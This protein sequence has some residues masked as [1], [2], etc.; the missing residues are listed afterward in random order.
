M[1]LGFNEFIED[2]HPWYVSLWE[3]GGRLA[4][5]NPNKN[6]KKNVQIMLSNKVYLA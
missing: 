5:P 4:M 2:W 1:R 3:E 6:F